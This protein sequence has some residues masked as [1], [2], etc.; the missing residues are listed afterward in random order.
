MKGPIF[1]AIIATTVLI[2]L[3]AM[4]ALAQ[5]PAGKESNWLQTIPGKGW[6]MLFRLHG[7]LRP[8]FDKTWRPGDPE[9]VK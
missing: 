7:P 8:W 3:S 2:A 9:V 4:P 6:N 5:A 1:T